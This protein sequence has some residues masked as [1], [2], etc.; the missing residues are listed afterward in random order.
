[1]S[2]KEKMSLYRQDPEVF[3]RE[4]LK[5]EPTKQQIDLLQAVAKPGAKVSVRS[6]HGTGKTT[7]MAWLVLWFLCTRKNVKI[8]CTA[9]TQAQL[10]DVL[11]AEIA[12]WRERMPSWWRTIWSARPSMATTRRSGW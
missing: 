10:R 1:M 9:P 3:V 11:W 12:K 8:P 2:V 6:G 7:P 5:G 4:I